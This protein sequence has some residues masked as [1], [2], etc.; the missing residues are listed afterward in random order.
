MQDF[1]FCFG[2]QKTVP[3]GCV[4]IWQDSKKRFNVWVGK[5]DVH[6]VMNFVIN[7]K[8]SM[9]CFY[10]EMNKLF[11]HHPNH[12]L[13]FIT[14]VHSH[15][16]ASHSF[17]SGFYLRL[18]CL[19]F[20]FLQIEKTDIGLF[21]NFG[22]SLKYGNTLFIISKSVPAI[23]KYSSIFF[24]NQT[25]IMIFCFQ[26]QIPCCLGY[27]FQI[28]VGKYIFEIL[29]LLLLI[30]LLIIVA[31]PR[32]PCLPAI[33]VHSSC[34]HQILV[35]RQIDLFRVLQVGSYPKNRIHCLLF[36][37]PDGDRTQCNFQ[38][39]QIFKH[40]GDHFFQLTRMMHRQGAAPDF[41]QCCFNLCF[42]CLCFGLFNI[43][44]AAI[45]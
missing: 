31:F 25:S 39:I 11:K 43:K 21:K 35:I 23:E 42:P 37:Q 33:L 36:K 34:F 38:F 30:V 18:P 13:Q 24:N 19:S 5:P 41:F 1:S 40:H 32:K 14:F 26:D 9:F 8:P 29:V 17:Q 6:I 10:F 16:A 12:L 7:I 3:G 2:I 15:R 45:C 44:V 28:I 22:S 20:S 4:E 27:C